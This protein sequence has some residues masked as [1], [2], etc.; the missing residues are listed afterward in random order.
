MMKVKVQIAS[1]KDKNTPQPANALGMKP[2]LNHRSAE[3]GAS[4]S[5]EYQANFVRIGMPTDR[6]PPQRLQLICFECLQIASTAQDPQNIEVTERDDDQDCGLYQPPTQG[7]QGNAP[8][9]RF[10][11]YVKSGDEDHIDR[12]DNEIAGDAK[13]KEP[14]VRHD[15][16]RGLR[17]MS[18]LTSWART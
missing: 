2:D 13:T 11:D 8:I 5:G 6:Q 17:G 7:E 12:E 1:R 4:K 9:D 3:G 14:F 18:K 10:E 16:Q 15:V